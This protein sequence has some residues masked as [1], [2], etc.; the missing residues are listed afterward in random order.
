MAK[1]HNVIDLKRRE[2]FIRFSLITAYCL[3]VTSDDLSPLITLTAAIFKVGLGIGVGD[4]LGVG[5]SAGLFPQYICG[6]GCGVIV[7]RGASVL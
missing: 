7:V 4:D 1:R 6:V 2:Y 3:T 5:V